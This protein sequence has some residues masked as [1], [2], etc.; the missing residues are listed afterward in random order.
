MFLNCGDKLRTLVVRSKRP[1]HIPNLIPMAVCHWNEHKFWNDWA[2]KT[3]TCIWHLLQLQMLRMYETSWSIWTEFCEFEQCVICTWKW[4]FSQLQQTYKMNWTIWWRT[5]VHDAGYM[6]K[7]HSSYSVK[8]LHWV[9]RPFKVNLRLLGW[10][11]GF[12]SWTLLLP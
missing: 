2:K 9:S 1:L 3:R 8:I 5:V 7:D 6:M 10:S 12:K 11:Y 4:T